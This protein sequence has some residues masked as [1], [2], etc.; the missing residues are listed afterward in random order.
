MDRV[1]GAHVPEIVKKTRSLS[2][3]SSSSSITQ[4]QE[5]LKEVSNTILSIILNVGQDINDRLKKLVNLAPCMLFM[6]GNP[7]EP[8][9]GIL[10]VNCPWF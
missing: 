8:R 7:E 4:P 1:D 6:K 5:K 9:C 3:G 2:D 10:L